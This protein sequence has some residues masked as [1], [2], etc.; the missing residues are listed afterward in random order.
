MVIVWD[1]SP[2]SEILTIPLSGGPGR[3]AYSY[4]GSKLVVSQ[5]DNGTVMIYDAKSGEE[6][7]TIQKEYQTSILDVDISTEN[8]LIA[9]ASLD[10]TTD[11]WDAT[12]GELILSLPVQDGRINQIS[13]SPSGEQLAIASDDFS[14][15]IWSASAGELIQ[16]YEIGSGALSLAFNLDETLLAVGSKAG[17][18]KVFDLR[19][20]DQRYMFHGHT[21]SIEA[22]SFNPT[23]TLLASASQDSTTIVWDVETGQAIHTIAAYSLPIT[24]ISF[25]PEG[26]TLAMVGADGVSRIWKVADWEEILTL[27]ADEFTKGSYYGLA[28]SPD[29]KHLT[30]AGANAIR[31]F[32]LDIEEL[33]YLARQRLTREFTYYECITYLHSDECIENEQ[34]AISTQLTTIDETETKVCQI[35]DIGGLEDNAINQNVYQGILT[36]ASRFDWQS[37][38]I[39]TIGFG[40]F[41][42]YIEDAL[43]ANC[44]LIITIYSD[45]SGVAQ[46]FA[47]VN[48]DVNFLMLDYIGESVPE[49]VW[50]QIYAIDQAAFLAGYAAASVTNTGVVGTFGGVNNPSVAA[51][52]IGF[53]Q[54]VYYYNQKND[55]EVK[56]IGWDSTQ[57][58]G[59]FIGDFCCFE[60]GYQLTEQLIAAGADI[61]MPVAGPF[62]GFGAVEG[63]RI[64]ENILIVG[65]DIDWAKALPQYADVILTSVE[66]RYNIS[67]VSTI[68]TID[69]GEFQGGLHIGT[70]ASGDVGISPFHHFDELIS[71]AVKAD[72][73]EI[74]TGIMSGDIA[75]TP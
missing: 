30:I 21:G 49:N 36:G 28:F 60:E 33:I 66:K 43:A 64:N 61:I 35:T 24:D 11:I 16:D 40:N 52:M 14:V 58:E 53:E 26:S 4:D 74:V 70:L 29:G 9:T 44:D 73:A 62:P 72:L 15:S 19:S 27:T 55:T 7:L 63:A 68:A 42:N 50:T 47:E 17:L 22:L 2:G 8:L 56:V 59:L 45:M 38:V 48:P 18:L 10:G 69:Q 71:P 39:E 32:T 75:T 12:T 25:D 37:M 57:N 65:V 54:G 23:G 20:G 51:F 34:V 5:G 6:S 41:T 67:V 13:F 1:L 3:V 31:T 46:G